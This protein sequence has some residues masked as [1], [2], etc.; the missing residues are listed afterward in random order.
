MSRSEGIASQL[1]MSPSTARSRLVKMLLFRELQRSNNDNCF[2]CG[3]KIK[4]I[5]H[6][7]IEHKRPWLNVSA[8]LYWDL[9]NIE[10]SHLTCNR[11]HS[12]G[13]PAAHG[14]HVMYDKYGCRCQMCREYHSW[15]LR[16]HR[17]PRRKTSLLSLSGRT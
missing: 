9:D 1:G 4:D 10:F 12:N 2:K 15:H 14:N 13:V 16:V 6:L 17:R 11:P 7:S 5:D 3:D 8:D